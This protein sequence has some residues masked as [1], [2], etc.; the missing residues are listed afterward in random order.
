[1]IRR[2][3][4]MKLKEENGWIYLGNK[5]VRY[6][7]GQPGVRNMLVIGVNP[8]TAIPEKD[9]PTIRKV[10]KLTALGEYDGWIM[11]N[12]YPQITSHPQELHESANKELMESNLDNLK[13]LQK[14]YRID[15][16]WAAWGD[17]IDN[18]SYLGEALVIIQDILDGDIQWFY[19]G[20]L[21][22]RGNPRHPLYMK[23]QED[24]NRFPVYDYAA[25]YK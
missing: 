4:G 25:Y 20:R 21:T 10:R 13:Q 24:F 23:E 7:L 1:M 3:N 18:R 17:A 8:S 22:R 11:V 15:A 12:L 6:V 9:D 2:E 19:R 5:E 14:Q 16:V